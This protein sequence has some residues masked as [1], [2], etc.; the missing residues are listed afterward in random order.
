MIELRDGQVVVAVPAVA[1]VGAVPQAAVVA[2]DD[3]GGIAGVDPDLVVVPVHAAG[4]AGKALA[5]VLAGDQLQVSLEHPV[6]VLR[7]H[8]DVGEVEGPPDHELAAVPLAPGPAA[9]IGAEEG[10][11]GALD[12]GIDDVG[13]GGGDGD[14]DPPQRP[15]RE[16]L[17]RLRCLPGPAGPPV[18]G[19]I[20]AAARRLVRTLPAGAEGPALAPE[21]PQGREQLVRVLRVDGQGRAARGQVRTLQ[22]LA[23]GHAAVGGLVEAPVGGIAPQ[24]SGDAGIDRVGIARVDDDLRDPLRV[25]QAHVLPGV[26]AVG[27]LVDAVADGDGVAGPGLPRTHPVGVRMVGIEGDGPDG[28]HR[29]SVEDRGEGGAPVPGLPHPAGRCPHQ[30]RGPTV[31]LGPSGQG[32]DAPRHGGGA[33][34][35]DAEAGKAGGGC[36]GG[37]GTDRR[38]RR[39]VGEGRQADRRGKGQGEGAAGGG[40]VADHGRASLHFCTADGAVGWGAVGWTNCAA[41]TGAFTS[42]LLRVRRWRWGEPLGPLSCSKGNQT[43]ATFS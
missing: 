31:G 38:F 28:L 33:D 4:D 5:P 42:I 22:D 13:V 19:D 34:V 32:G 36:G 27:G 7:I 9:V 3:V 15:R 43:P 30:Q 12:H 20:E 29:L 8:G 35:A 2:G 11:A 40:P 18:G 14:T 41:S 10:G 25:R 21:V 1:P 23:P 39:G 26:A 17:V 16:A 6:G 37:C 24:P